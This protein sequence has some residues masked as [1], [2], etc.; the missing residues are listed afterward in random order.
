MLP[1]QADI[2]C[3][4]EMPIKPAPTRFP[5]TVA[6]RREEIAGWIFSPVVIHAGTRP[7][8]VD[9]HPGAS[10]TKR[11]WHLVGDPAFPNK[12]YSFA[13]Y[14][15]EQV[16]AIV[17]ACDHLGTGESSRPPDGGGV[18][19]DHLTEARA[20]VARQIQTGLALGALLPGMAPLA[21][22]LMLGIGHG[23]GAAVVTELQGRLDLYDAVGILGWTQQAPVMPGTDR[24]AVMAALVP[25]A[26]GYLP[27]TYRE[28]SRPFCYGSQVPAEVIAA[29]ERQATH[30]PAG[31]PPTL[32]A[33]GEAA[34]LAAA[35][36]V[37]V[38]LAFGERDGSP[39]P[40][41]EV[42]CYPQARDI[43]LLVLPDSAHCHNLAPTRQQLW[44]HLALWI[45]R[46]AET[47]SLAAAA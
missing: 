28:R 34:R 22:P 41:A 37:P 46:Q 45:K 27:P 1:T 3:I 36:E 20:Q 6:G 4:L 11:Y 5:V 24:E 44:R 35:I 17:V 14:L 26:R 33:P 42:A 2:D 9:L 39:D 25:D 19:L 32:M 15:V 40:H 23:M 47:L 31:I 21:P 12:S 18:T 10:Y 30:L 43:T 8:V 16:G 29:D 13:Q 38:Y 7:I